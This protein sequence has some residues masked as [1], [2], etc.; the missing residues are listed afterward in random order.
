[1][2]IISEEQTKTLKDLRSENRSLLK[3]NN[4]STEDI[5]ATIVRADKA[6]GKA[7]ESSNSILNVLPF[8]LQKLDQNNI[9]MAK[10]NCAKAPNACLS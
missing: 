8:D 2:E 5:L 1:M 10:E 7:L 6:I 4:A 3:M 9:F